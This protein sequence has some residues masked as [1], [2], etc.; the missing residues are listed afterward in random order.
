[1]TL[2]TPSQDTSRNLPGRKPR[3]DKERDTQETVVEDAGDTEDNKRDLVH[4][5]G[6]TIDL[7]TSPGDLSKDD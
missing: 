4:G 1:M 5:E 3:I 6:G 7:P 2:K